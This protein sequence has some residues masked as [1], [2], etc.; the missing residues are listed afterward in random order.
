MSCWFSTLPDWVNPSVL[1]YLTCLDISVREL[2]QVD[3]KILGKLPALCSLE[4]EVDEK[5]L[6]VLKT[7]VVGAGSFPCLVCCD[8]RRFVWPVVFQRG[9]MP[10]LR[11]IQFLL[12]YVMRASGVACSGGG[13]NFGL[14]NLPS[15]ERVDAFLLSERAS[16]Q[17]AERAKAVLI[18]AAEMHPNNP[19]HDIAFI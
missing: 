2:H 13:L 4:L 16:T 8:L 9:A 1:V 12:C 14:G 5:N 10:R 15:L 17:E 11:E 3:L 6:S 19:H 18:H 7:F